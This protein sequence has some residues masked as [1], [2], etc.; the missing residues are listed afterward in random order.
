MIEVSRLALIILIAAATPAF[1][2]PVGSTARGPVNAP[3]EGAASGLMSPA[4]PSGSGSSGPAGAPRVDSVPYELSGRA[5]TV[6]G[7]TLSI[8]PDGLPGS[9]G[10]SW[11]GG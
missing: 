7:G 11:G 6:A 9:L 3:M 4:L 10:R 2:K 8:I 1:A 5:D